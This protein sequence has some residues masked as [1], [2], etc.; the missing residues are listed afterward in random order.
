[1]GR[2]VPLVLL[3]LLN[4]LRAARGRPLLSESTLLLLNLSANDAQTGDEESIEPSGEDVVVLCKE[5]R[6]RFQ[7]ALLGWIKGTDVSENLEKNRS[8]SPN[9]FNV[10]LRLAPCINCGGG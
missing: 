4:D 6:P 9:V 10:R 2:D 5:L 3:P 1:M 7:L 8:G